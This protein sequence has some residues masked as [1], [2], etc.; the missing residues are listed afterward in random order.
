M[1]TALK[2]LGLIVGAGS[3]VCLYLGSLETP[4]DIETVK[5]K[6]PTEQRFQRRRLFTARI[7]FALFGSSLPLSAC[8][9][10]ALRG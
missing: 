4:W 1:K 2:M 7:G 6:S 9:H 10:A 5:G 3:A 8:S